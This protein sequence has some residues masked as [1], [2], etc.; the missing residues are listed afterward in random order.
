MYPLL[1]ENRNVSFNTIT[2]E[3]ELI[4]NSKYKTRECPLKSISAKEKLDTHGKR[5]GVDY[6]E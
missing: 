5:V 3:G 2:N 6:I 1:T 4:E